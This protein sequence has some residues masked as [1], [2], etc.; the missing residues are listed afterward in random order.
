[1]IGERGSLGWALV[2]R[3]PSGEEALPESRRQGRGREGGAGGLWGSGGR[4]L[5]EFSYRMVFIPSVKSEL[6]PEGCW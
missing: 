1:M 2:E 5:R 3:L 6:V 4:K